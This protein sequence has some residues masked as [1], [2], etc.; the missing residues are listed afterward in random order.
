M[1]LDGEQPQRILIIRLSS[2]GD[3]LLATPLIRALRAHFPQTRLDFV[4]KS[5][6]AELLQ[7]HPAIAQIYKVNPKAGWPELRALG[8][9]LRET[10]YDVVFDIH[11]NFRSRYLTAAA[12]PRRVLRY[13]KHV[14]RRWILVQTKINLMKTVPP[15]YRRYLGAASP[16]GIVPEQ[17]HQ[18]RQ[19]ELFWGEN[20]EHE[21]TAALRTHGCESNVPL[22][23][24]APGAGYFTKRWPPAYFG[25]LAAAL[26]RFGNQVVLLGGPQETELA[27]DIEKVMKEVAIPTS[28]QNGT[29]ENNRNSKLGSSINLVGKLSLLAAAAVIKRCCLLITNDSGPMHIAEAV[30]TPLVAIFGSTVR[31]FGFFPQN[32][33]SRVIEH[34]GLSCRPCSHL[35]YDRC[36]RGHFRCMREILPET[37]LPLA[38]KMLAASAADAAP[39]HR[40]GQTEKIIHNLA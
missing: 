2:I 21:A 8:R 29:F 27:K 10:R 34:H 1:N 17:R 38:Q 26:A 37:V 15:I 3:I 9:E 33:M 23:A 25:Q 40:R 19:L 11:K 32:K 13:R 18:D 5:D 14:F 4:V 39:I 30:G 7:H 36:P 16:L 12:Q 22:I 6:F 31:E 28:P 35:G 20:E 24:V